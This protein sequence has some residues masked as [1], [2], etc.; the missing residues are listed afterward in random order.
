MICHPGFIRTHLSDD[1]YKRKVT[2]E[3]LSYRD[4]QRQ[5]VMC[6]LC[7]KPFAASYIDKHRADE[8]Y[9]FEYALPDLPPGMLQ[10][11]HVPEAYEISWPRVIKHQGCPVPQ[12]PWRSKNATTTPLYRH[13][14]HRHPYDT[15]HI[16]RDGDRPKC[17]LCGLQCAFPSQQP[18]LESEDCRRGR[19]LQTKRVAANNLRRQMEVVITVGGVPLET[20]QIYKYLGRLLACN[21]DDWPAIHMNLKKARS[22]WASLSRVLVRE[23]S[24]PRISGLFYK[25][26]VQAVLL[27]GCES[28][29]LTDKV[30]KTLESFHNRAARRISRKMPYKVGEDWVYPPIAEAREEAGFYTIQHYVEKRQNRV[31]AYIATRPIWPHCVY[32][33]A[34]PELQSSRI[35]WWTKVLHP[36]TPPPTPPPSPPG[37]A[38]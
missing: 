5:R 34:N 3:G 21:D 14:Q 23:G 27:Y 10:D 31:A 28:W 30:W 12:C 26:V 19:L 15:I 38:P 33:D 29:V 8:H 22:R 7:Q 36:P 35:R 16:R 11:A 1:A 25:A 6:P 13:F 37:Q 18:H 2:G 17:V 4:R 20:V 32:A 24:T 9:K